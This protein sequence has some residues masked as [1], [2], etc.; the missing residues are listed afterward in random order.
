MEFKIL[1][2]II[3]VY[4]GKLL[5]VQRSS[6]A[7]YLPSNWTFVCGHLNFGETLEQAVHREL[8]EEVSLSCEILGIVGTNEWTWSEGKKQHLQV[9]F[10][11]RVFED[12]V[13]LDESCEAYRWIETY[14]ETE[15]QTLDDFN[16]RMFKQYSESI[17]LVEKI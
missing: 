4:D 13:K 2:G 16:K 5:I 3:P 7:T 14:R 6:S 9:N 11:V 10:V 15:I 1:V 12:I 8:K 17:Y